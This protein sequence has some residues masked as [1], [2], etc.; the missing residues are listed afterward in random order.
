MYAY[1]AT[2]RFTSARKYKLINC[3][4]LSGCLHLSKYLVAYK[5]DI[6]NFFADVIMLFFNK[7]SQLP[8]ADMN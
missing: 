4:N 8:R 2:S 6:G 5:T 3:L 1:K 7:R